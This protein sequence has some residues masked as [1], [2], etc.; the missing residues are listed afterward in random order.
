MKTKAKAILL[1]FDERDTFRKGDIIKRKGS[2]TLLLAHADQVGHG[3]HWK[4]QRLLIIDEK[5]SCTGDE[6]V[7]DISGRVKFVCSEDESTRFDEKIIASYPRLLDT[8]TIPD[9]VV[10]SYVDASGNG[11]CE[12]WYERKA[13][14]TEIV[15]L[16]AKEI[17]LQVISGIRQDEKENACVSDMVKNLEKR[18]F[19]ASKENARLIGKITELDNKPTDAVCFMTWLM[20]TESPL[21]S[22]TF[23]FNADKEAH[24]PENLY[25]RFKAKK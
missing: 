15:F 24:T 18:L 23:E 11:G 10:E 20:S 3:Q 2:D 12:F 17:A 14:E 9:H 16:D 22:M 13:E 5:A 4:A 1:E 19:D 8:V 6:V 25:K 7:Y 21:I